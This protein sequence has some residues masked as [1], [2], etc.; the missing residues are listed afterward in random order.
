MRPLRKT[1]PL[2]AV[3]HTLC[4]QTVISAAAP[5]QHLPQLH[6]RGVVSCRAGCHCRCYFLLPTYPLPTRDIGLHGYLLVYNI[7]REMWNSNFDDIVHRAET[8][9]K[10][11]EIASETKRTH[12]DF[13][14]VQRTVGEMLVLHA[15]PTTTAT[16]LCTSSSSAPTSFKFSE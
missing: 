7:N 11:G 14:V 15:R 12:R 8:R 4:T 10:L 3:G 1:D 5:E 2:S 13:P 9:C 6:G 16:H